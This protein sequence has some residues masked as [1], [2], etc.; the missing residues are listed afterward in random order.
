MSNDLKQIRRLTAINEGW[1]RFIIDLD[2]DR[3][4][5][6]KMEIIDAKKVIDRIQGMKVEVSERIRTNEKTKQA[7]LDKVDCLDDPYKTILLYRYRD[8]L[9]WDQIAENMNY[10]VRWV[11]RMHKKAL[12]TYEKPAS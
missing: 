2:K 4:R 9:T 8:G 7:I 12:M 10:N 11:Y 1:E 5:L 6:E 3:E